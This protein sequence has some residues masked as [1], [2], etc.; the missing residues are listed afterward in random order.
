[1]I[2]NVDSGSIWPLKRDAA[3]KSESLPASTC[4][5]LQPAYDMQQMACRTMSVTGVYPLKHHWHHISATPVPAEL[6]FSFVGHPA[7]FLSAIG[8]Q[9]SGIDRNVARHR[10]QTPP[11][12]QARPS[13]CKKEG[14]YG[15]LRKII[16]AGATTNAAHSLQPAYAHHMGRSQ[17]MKNDG[18]LTK[19]WLSCA[20]RTEATPSRS[21]TASPSCF[22]ASSTST[23]AMH[24]PCTQLPLPWRPSYA[25]SPTGNWHLDRHPA[26]G[27][28]PHDRSQTT[29]HQV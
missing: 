15:N 28:E 5:R 14:D 23:C 10:Q 20:D 1:M 18:C 16:M 21:L 4:C 9:D 6:L 8:R 17:T 27:A 24:S 26:T 12:N 2:G 19:H 22:C 7:V 25:C 3:P 13:A 29:R 11:N